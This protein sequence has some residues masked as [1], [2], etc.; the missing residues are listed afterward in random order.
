MK[1]TVTII[2]IILFS[3]SCNKSDN[4][5]IVDASKPLAV[6]ENEYEN[7][8][9]IFQTSTSSQSKAIQIATES[10]YSHC[11]LLFNEGQWL[12]YE[13]VQP[14]KMTP[15]NEWIKRGENGKYVIKRLKNR[16][17]LDHNKNYKKFCDEANLF[18]NQDYD[19]AFDWSD[20]EVYCS[21]LVWKTYKRGL[22]IELSQ[23]E[24]LKDFNLQ[25][26]AVQNK[27]KER[28]GNNIPYDQVVVSPKALFESKLLKTVKQN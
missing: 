11:G 15:L 5:K 26:L 19:F 23:L 13:A 6:H 22:G 4:S 27:L 28:Y 24:Q 12:V 10:K 18:L 17:V 3:Y 16:K 9:I 2:F 14:V 25:N 20:K 21:E 8:D 7:G 1:I